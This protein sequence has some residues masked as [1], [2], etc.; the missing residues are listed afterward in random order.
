MRFNRRP[1]PRLHIIRQARIGDHQPQ[2]RQNGEEKGSYGKFAKVLLGP[3]ATGHAVI[4]PGPAANHDCPQNANKRQF[5]GAVEIVP[6]CFKVRGNIALPLSRKAMLGRR[7]LD[8]LQI[9]HIRHN[10]YSRHK[11]KPDRLCSM[12]G[13]TV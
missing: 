1:D 6:I 4:K 12:D 2:H 11:T 8:K 9:I 13:F 5:R 10:R 7:G 3:V